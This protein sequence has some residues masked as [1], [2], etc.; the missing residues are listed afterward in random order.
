MNVTDALKAR[1][2]VRAF[3]DKPVAE[4]LIRNILEAAKYAPSGGNLQPWKVHVV[5]GGA[6]DRLVATVKKAIADN[7]LAD[8]SELKIY[9][10]KLWEPYRTRRYDLGEAMYA[11]LGIPREDKPAR[12][13]RFAQNLEFFGAPVGLFFSLDRGF[14]KPQW[15]HLGMLMQSIALVAVE[16]GLASCMQEAWQ[17]RAK[18]VAAFLGLPD[19]QQ[20]YCGMALGYADEAAPVN[21]LRS[22][23]APLDDFVTF[24]RE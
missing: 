17:M 9:P 21:R 5:M 7:P 23:R 22:E 24:I 13:A 16:K 3:L 15:A 10:E 11:L 14:D 1:I 20:L 2:S 8:E 6:R 18:T 12:L 19:S 4:E